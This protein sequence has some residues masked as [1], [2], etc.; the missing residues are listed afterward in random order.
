MSRHFTAAGGQRYR[1]DEPA[2]EDVRADGER[3]GASIT[4]Y[5]EAVGMTPEQLLKHARALTAADHEAVAD[6]LKHVPRKYEEKVRALSKP[7]Q[8]AEAAIRAVE[9]LIANQQAVFA[10]PNYPKET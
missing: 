2:Y 8:E 1:R 4:L 10:A 5:G 6:L 3:F 7:R 9:I